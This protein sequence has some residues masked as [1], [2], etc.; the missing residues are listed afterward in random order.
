MKGLELGI[1]QIRRGVTIP[2]M[3]SDALYFEAA[4]IVSNV[5]AS[6]GT[7]KN[8]CFGSSYNNKK[9]LFALVSETCK[10]M[11]NIDSF[12]VLKF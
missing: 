11:K 2:A 10:S 5:S 7:I 8:L 6:K 12:D 1:E 9:A 3:P 4:K